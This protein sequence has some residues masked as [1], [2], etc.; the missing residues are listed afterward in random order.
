M[1]PAQA[2]YH[3]QFLGVRGLSTRSFQREKAGV[4]EKYYRATSHKYVLTTTVGTFGEPGSV[5]LETS[6]APCCKAR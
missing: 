5:I 3:L 6:P 4:I 2:H 1:S